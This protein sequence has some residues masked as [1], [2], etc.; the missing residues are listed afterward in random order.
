MFKALRNANDYIQTVTLF[1]GKMARLR[2]EPETVH[3]YAVA[4]GF[5]TMKAQSYSIL[6]AGY[7]ILDTGYW[8]LDTGCGILVAGYWLRDTGCGIL[9][10]GYWLLDTGCWLLVAG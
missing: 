2:P 5:F 8:L 6:D 7:W 1:N 4:C 10:A 9:V 3:G